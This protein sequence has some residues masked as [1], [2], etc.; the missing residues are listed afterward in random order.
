M[1]HFPLSI[2]QEKEIDQE[3]KPKPKQQQNRINLKI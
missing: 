1:P 2:D 3:G